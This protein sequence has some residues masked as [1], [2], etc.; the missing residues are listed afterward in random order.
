MAHLILMGT[1]YDL[2]P[3]KIV[4]LLRNYAE[5]ARELDNPLPERPSFFL[6]PPSSL[7]ENGREVI[8]PPGVKAL[9]HEVEL[10]VIIG[11]G[12]RYIIE[13]EALEHVKAFTIML[14]M[15]AR[16]LQ[17]AAKKSGLPWSESKGFDTFA[18]VG[19]SA[20]TPA[21]FD[22]HGRRIWLK[23]NG[24][25]RQDG[26][27]D[28]MLYPVERIISA[29]SGVMTLVEDDILM[30]G[31]PS[32]VGPVAPGDEIEAGIEGMEPLRCSISDGA[33]RS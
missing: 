8:F 14:D 7:L 10:A 4:C 22:H 11:S 3:S 21:E 17:D 33:N 5:H 30:T 28:G 25:V 1:D 15:T 27:T 26:N 32:G 19:P 23:V 6:K 12:G 13:D 9:H 18:P 31:T 2:R 20:L 16:D 29:V 24:E